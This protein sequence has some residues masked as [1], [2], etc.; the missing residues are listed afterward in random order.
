M[1]RKLMQGL[2]L[3]MPIFVV[4][5]LLCGWACGSGARSEGGETDYTQKP[6]TSVG[7]PADSMVVSLK[8][9]QP[10][11]SGAPLTA[12]MPEE[13]ATPM[14]KVE[15]EWTPDPAE[16]DALAR[17]MYNEARGCSTMEQAAVAWC[18]LNRVDSPL[19]YFPDTVLDVVTQP[20][21]FAYTDDTPLTEPL[22]ALAADVLTRWHREA[23]GEKNVG[24]VLPST[25]IYFI[26]D[27]RHNYFTEEWKGTDY[28]S[29][30][31]PDPYIGEVS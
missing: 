29:W 28:W 9:V 19:S 20:Y 13:K 8:C 2:L 6:E 16:V 24:R 21:Q 25:Y 30:N 18:V 31:L 4:V 15:S 17:T 22:R 27:G 14:E 5:G 11:L 1:K 26:G 12:V 3:L 23:E 7:K 10:D